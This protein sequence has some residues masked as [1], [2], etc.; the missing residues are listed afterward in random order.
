[1]CL[2]A[3]L[4]GLGSCRECDEVAPD[5]VTALQEQFHGKYAPI[6]STS[7]LALDVDRDGNAST[8]MLAEIGDLSNSWVEVRVYSTGS[9][10]AP[11]SLTF[12]HQWPKQELTPAEP[13]NDNPLSRLW[14]ATKVVYWSFSFDSSRTRLL[15]EPQPA[16]Q[17][18]PELYTPAE[19]VLV[20]GDGQ[21]EVTLSKR[22]YTTEGW[23]TARIVTLYGR[24][25]K[26]T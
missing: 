4:A 15:L 25:T 5:G 9:N 7:S 21:I 3:G 14:Y 23:K 8:D 1:M 18:N 22:L 6:R 19:S 10:S 20:K 12:I 11:A 13:T 17:S 26:T 2:L 24:F 16:D